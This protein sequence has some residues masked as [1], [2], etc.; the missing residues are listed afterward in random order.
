M[1]RFN[2]IVTCLRGQEPVAASELADL[3]REMGD[4]EPVVNVTKVAGLLT[5]ETSLDP[6][7][8]VEQLRKMLEDEP[9]KVGY[10]MRV[11]PVEEVVETRLERIAEAVERLAVKIPEDAT[12]RVTVEKRHTQLSS[13]DIIEAAAKRVER[14]V[15]LENPDWIVLIQVIGGVTGVAVI[16]P[17]QI[18]SSMKR[19]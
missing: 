13:R 19:Q 17:G 16:K 4:P 2:L 6:F 12:Y 9:W 3:L 1:E 14:R 7:K 5:A 11:I 15:N 10:V 8:V 18:V